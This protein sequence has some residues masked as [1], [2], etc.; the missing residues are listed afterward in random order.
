VPGSTPR[1][2]AASHS[3]RYSSSVVLSGWTYRP[4][5]DSVLIFASASRASR[6]VS[7]VCVI[8]LR[9]PSGPRGASVTNRYLTSPDFRVI[10]LIGSLATDDLLFSP[11]NPMSLLGL[12][13]HR[14][15]M[16]TSLR[17]HASEVKTDS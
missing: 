3:P 1:P 14:I 7:N 11:L 17:G 4:L 2:I 13:L 10:F 12:V 8:C 6:I 9:L 5:L 16:H 15:P